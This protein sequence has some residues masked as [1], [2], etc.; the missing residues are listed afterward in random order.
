[1]FCFFSSIPPSG[2]TGRNEA[3]HK[4]LNQYLAGKT[5][6]TIETLEGLIYSRLFQW[7]QTR[8]FQHPDQ[9]NVHSIPH[10][11]RPSATSTQVELQIP[12]DSSAANV[13]DLPQSNISPTVLKDIYSQHEKLYVCQ[14]NVEKNSSVRLNFFSSSLKVLDRLFTELSQIADVE[15]NLQSNLKKLG[16]VLSSHDTSKAGNLDVITQHYTTFLETSS[17]CRNTVTTD[18]LLRELERNREQYDGFFGS[19]S[20]KSMDMDTPQNAC[21]MLQASAEVLKVV[22]VIVTP[23]AIADHTVF[24]PETVEHAEPFFLAM[25]VVSGKLKLEPGSGSRPMVAEKKT[26]F[27]K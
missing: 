22:I 19:S 10:Q 25:N 6:T 9:A 15:G 5:V 12:D 3:L 26:G 27:N 17:D 18:E 7:N 4:V 24:I 13:V 20:S 23:H 1:M 16:V 14:K 2:G 21:S 8:I 11:N